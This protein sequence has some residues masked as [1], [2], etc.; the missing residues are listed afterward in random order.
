MIA[1]ETPYSDG[2]RC[3]ANYTRGRPVRIAVGQIADYTGKISSDNSGREV[4]QGAALMAMSALSKAGVP[5]VERFD[6]VPPEADRVAVAFVERQPRIRS[7]GGPSPVGQQRRLAGPGRSGDQ[8]G[9]LHGQLAARIRQADHHAVNSQPQR[10]CRDV[11][12]D[13]DDAGV[14]DRQRLHPR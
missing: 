12:D 9:A 3:M 14:D 8:D 1:N 4:T 7:A 10:Q 13:A 6:G 11:V 2:L 5:L